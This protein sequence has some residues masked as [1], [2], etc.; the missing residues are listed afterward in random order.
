MVDVL[1]S[2]IISRPREDVAPYAADPAN[3][4]EWYVNIES[5]RWLTDPVLQVGSRVAFSARFLGRTLS[6]VYEIV[7]FDPLDRLVMRTAEGPFPMETT[8]V[9]APAG[10]NATRMELRNTGNPRGFFRMLGPLL[11]RSMR[12]ANSK[13]LQ[14]LKK[15]LE[16]R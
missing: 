1:T 8:Y 9:W 12:K 16:S 14:N 13:D 15:L 11:E 10:P 4:P 2:I 6:Y 3:A 5:A 7:Q